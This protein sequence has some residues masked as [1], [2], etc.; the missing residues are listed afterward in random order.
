ML[1][2][3]QLKVGSKLKL[4]GT[5]VSTSGP[6]GE[7]GAPFIVAFE[8]G[9]DTED[10]RYHFSER[11]LKYAEVISA[12]LTFSD[13]QIDQILSKLDRMPSVAPSGYAEVRRW[14]EAHREKK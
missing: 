12:P 8:G 10:G 9:E 14:L 1:D 11:F 4:T 13:E 6:I 2:P 3:K 5:I 7:F